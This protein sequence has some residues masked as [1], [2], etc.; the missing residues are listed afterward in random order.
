MVRVRENHRLWSVTSWMRRLKRTLGSTFLKCYKKRRFKYSDT[1][2]D[3]YAPPTPLSLW[4]LRPVAPAVVVRLPW[5]L[6]L[7]TGRGN[8]LRLSRFRRTDRVPLMSRPDPSPYL[9]TLTH[10]SG[11]GYPPKQNEP[12]MRSL[13]KGSTVRLLNYSDQIFNKIIPF[14]LDNPW[15]TS[16]RKRETGSS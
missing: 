5:P 6:G 3:P 1:D 8:T 14:I 12:I 2:E 4:R 16:L 7:S 10:R 15:G 13:W 9:P 11:S